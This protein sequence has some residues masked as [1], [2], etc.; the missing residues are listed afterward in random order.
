[1]QKEFKDIKFSDFQKEKI[2]KE[3]GWEEVPL[4]LT[5]KEQDETHVQKMSK[6]LRNYY[7]TFWVKPYWTEE[8]KEL[9]KMDT[10]VAF[11]K[12]LPL[13]EYE[14]NCKKKLYEKSLE[15]ETTENLVDLFG[16]NCIDK[17]FRDLFVYK[18]GV[19]IQND[20]EKISEE[21]FKNKKYELGQGIAWEFVTQFVRG[22]V[23]PLEDEST[24]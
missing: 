1:M 14:Y 13:L 22:N 4:K 5:E 3:R 23:I 2:L 9:F 11:R 15:K 12:E 8:Q 7:E 6:R 19:I 16:N 17:S 10:W 18:L 21:N 20:L 24:L